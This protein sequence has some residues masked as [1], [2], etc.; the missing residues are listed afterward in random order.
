MKS[1]KITS[2]AAV[3]L[4]LVFQAHSGWAQD[5]NLIAIDAAQVPTCGTFWS[6]R[7]LSS[8]HLS[9]PLP[10]DPFLQY[11]DLPISVPVYQFPDGSFLMMD[12]DE[13]YA[14]L[15]EQRQIDQALGSLERQLGLA[16]MEE[17]TPS[18]PSYPSIDTNSFYLEISNVTDT[19]TLVVHN[20]PDAIAELLSKE[21]LTD[22]FL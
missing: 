18:W 6:W 10:M 3:I 20:A 8:G 4:A 19:A 1:S 22:P 2:G 17:E 7:S 11:P 15:E 9:P 21:S 16:P 12:S 13:A 14:A 5:T